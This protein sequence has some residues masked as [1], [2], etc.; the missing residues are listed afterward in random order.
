MSFG[1]SLRRSALPSLITK[2]ETVYTKKLK[3]LYFNIRDPKVNKTPSTLIMKYKF[4]YQVPNLKKIP[5]QPSKSLCRTGS[6]PAGNKTEALSCAPGSSAK[7]STSS[8]SCL[9]G[10]NATYSDYCCYGSE[11]NNDLDRACQAGT[12]AATIAYGSNYC[13]SG[14]AAA[15]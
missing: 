8:K 6:A 3:E 15:L 14:N 1:S 13:Y 2:Q 7:L 5:D 12:N 11:N 10:N 4:I 9:G